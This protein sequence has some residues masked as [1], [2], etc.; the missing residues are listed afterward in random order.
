MRH[1]ARKDIAE[2]P[3]TSGTRRH[4]MSLAVLFILAACAKIILFG[5]LSWLF[6]S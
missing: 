3:W 2:F 1:T 5:S 4:E 6:L